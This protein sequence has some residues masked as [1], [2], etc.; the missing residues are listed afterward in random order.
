MKKNTSLIIQ[1]IILLLTAKAF[2]Q[3]ITNFTGTLPQASSPYEDIFIYACNLHNK[4]AYD[5]AEVE[6]KR[7]LFMSNYQNVQYETE[8]LCSLAALYELKENYPLAA[9]TC[10]KAIQTL[11]KKEIDPEKIDKLRLIHIRLLS[12]AALQSKEYLSNN[13]YIYS[14]MKLPQMSEQ[15][16]KEA[17]AA[18][19]SDALMN[20]R[21]DYAQKTFDAAVEALPNVWNTQERKI[22]FSAFADLNKF[23]PKKQKLAGYLSFV[24]GLGQLYAANYKDSLNAFL[25]NGSLITLSVWSLCTLDFW[26]FSLLEFNPL[27]RFMQGNIYNAQKDAYQYNL[28]KQQELSQPILQELNKK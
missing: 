7:Y 1:L 17:Y 3:G 15:I 10:Q 28:K 18:A 20:G 24:P 11:A 19:I 8:A 27:I 14:Y 26:T 6:Y 25:L 9:E 12:L 23:K 16:K 13:L 5:Q 22:I 2:G 4:G 21:I